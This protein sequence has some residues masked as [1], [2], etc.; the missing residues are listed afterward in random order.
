LSALAPP[1]VEL[2]NLWRDFRR[3]AEYIQGNREWLLPLLEQ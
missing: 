3:V 2:Q 1:E